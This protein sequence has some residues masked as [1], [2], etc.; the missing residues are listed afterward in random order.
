MRFDHS[1][2]SKLLLDGMDAT[3]LSGGT[4]VRRYGIRDDRVAANRKSLSGGYSIRSLQD[5]RAWL[6]R[7]HLSC[8][9]CRSVSVAPR[10]LKPAARGYVGGL[11][12]RKTIVPAT[13]TSASIM[14]TPHVETAGMLPTAVPGATVSASG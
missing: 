13:M 4:I 6:E 11:T 10:R 14:T 7:F 9:G 1:D 5:N 3:L 12:R 2:S 8:S